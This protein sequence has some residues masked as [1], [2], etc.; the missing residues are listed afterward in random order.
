MS[1]SF[2]PGMI[3]DGFELIKK[4]PSGGMASIWRA[5]KKGI[6][7][8]VVLKIPFLDPGQDVSVIIGY[9]VEEMIARRLSGP[10]VPK[11]HA[12]GDLRKVPYIAMEFIDGVSV[13]ARAAEAPLPFEEVTRIG[14]E[15]GEALAALHEQKVAHLD[16]K[17]ENIFLTERGAVLLDFGLAHH[18]ELPDLLAEQSDVPMGTAAYISPEQ[19]LGI[20]NDQ[21]SDIFAL[22]CI[23]YQLASGVEPF[24]WPQTTAGMRRRLFQHPPQLRTLNAA[25]PRWLEQIIEKCMEV[26]RARRYTDAGQVVHDLRH[27]DQVRLVERKPEPTGLKSFLMRLFG[28]GDARAELALKKGANIGDGPSVVITAVDLSAGVDALAEEIRTETAIALAARK[29]SRL[30]CVAVLKTELIAD[31]PEVD[32]EGRSNYVNM[33]VALK[34]WAHPL[35]LPDGRASFHVLE[36]VSPADAILNFAERNHAGRIVMGARASSAMRRH[37]G[38]VSAKVVAEA[39]CS[40][41][42][43]RVKAIEI[44]VRDAEQERA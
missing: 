39:K 1:Q 25:V 27:P 12:F 6:D 30:A 24:G 14:I 43:V 10:H 22:G 26:D 9:E 29:D 19:V 3:I 2:S 5:R 7:G 34:D 31:R 33:L 11:F 21:A 4:L 41:S 37:L 36:A 40:V 38:S 8:E 28:G 16:I 44:A 15:T 42:V 32:A 18:A 17:P 23:L 35:H 13:A 20:R